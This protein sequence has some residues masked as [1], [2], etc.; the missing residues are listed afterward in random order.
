MYNGPPQLLA[1]AVLTTTYHITNLRKSSANAKVIMDSHRR[2]RS[3]EVAPSYPSSYWTLLQSASLQGASYG[4]CVYFGHTYRPLAKMEDVFGL[5]TIKDLF[6]LVTK[7]DV[8]G[9][10]H[11]LKNAGPL[12]HCIN[13]KDQ[14]KQTRPCSF[15]PRASVDIRQRAK[16]LS[17]HMYVAQQCLWQGLTSNWVR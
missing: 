12:G 15:V 11:L 6:Q 8:K 16:W 13:T 2:F 10:E 7:C 9:V 17:C 5:V 3:L 4:I 14:N 1:G